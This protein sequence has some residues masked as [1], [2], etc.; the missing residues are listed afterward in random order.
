VT[1]LTK[2][3]ANATLDGAPYVG[4][5]VATY[6]YA[7]VD[8]VTGYRRVIHP[9]VDQ[10]SQL[11]HDTQAIVKRTLTGVRLDK[12]D[13][14][15]FNSVSSRLELSMIIRGEEFKLGHYVPSDWVQLRTT[16]G[17]QSITSFYDENF[18]IDQQLPNAF[19]ANTVAGEP[20]SSALQRFLSRYPIDYHIQEPST[21]TT[22]GSWGAGTRGGQVLTQLAL[23]GD[24]LS[25]WFDHN[26][27]LQLRRTFDPTHELPDF[28]FD[29]SGHVLRDSIIESDNLVSAPNRFVVV[30][31]GAG[32]FDTPVV[33]SADVPSS[34]PHSVTNRG[35]VVSDVTARQVTSIEQAG[36]IASSLA[37]SQTLFQQVELDTIPDPRHDSYDVIL[38]RENKWIE[39]KWT[40]PLNAGGRMSHTLRRVFS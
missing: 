5:R 28:D 10:S 37:Q 11:R 36:R 6:R 33:G 2:T 4:Q 15:A 29:H 9:V 40:L 38:W 30:G 23:D 1:H 19:G 17:N 21:L 18:I 32:A 39:I 16:S 3:H 27:V 8:F 22:L 14:A 31:N 7:L 20:V 25:P 12:N 24:Y 13:T 26:S 35:F 34:A